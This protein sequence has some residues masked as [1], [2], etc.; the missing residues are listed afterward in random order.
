MAL[1]V[2]DRVQ[3]TCSSPGTGVV[4]LLGAV[5][6]FQTFSA[7]IG[8]AN[9][10]FY[11]I[12]DKTGSNWEVGI[13]TYATT[14]N[15]LT[16]TTIL[17]SSNAGLVVN[18][19]SGTQNVWGDYPA[20]KAI[21]K[22]ASGNAIGLGTPAAFVATN[23]T[24]LPLT[25]GVTGTLPIANGG[26]NSTATPTAGG[27]GYGTG[28]ANAYTA[29]GTS[30]N[31]LISAGASAPAFGN[32][33]LG[34]ANTNVSGALTAT[35]GGTGVAGTLTGVLYGNGTAAHSVATTAQ[36][37]TGMGVANT[38][39]SGY[40]SSTDWNTF[41]GKQAAGSYVTVGGALGTPSSGTLTNCTFPTLNQNTTGSSGSCTGNAATATTATN[42]TTVTA[43][44]LAG[45]V[46]PSTSGNVLTSNGTAWTSATPSGGFAAG[47][48]ILF[49]QAAAP[50]GWTKSATDN[51][52]AL[53]VVSGTTG[54][55]AGGSVAFSTAFAS[56]TPAGTVSVTV[57]IGTLASGAVTLATTQI[58]AHTHT[59]S[60]STN[61]SNGSFGSAGGTGMDNRTTVNSN[62]GGTGGGT[63]HTHTLSGAPSVTSATFTGTAINLAVQYCDVIICTKN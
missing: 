30:G 26:T 5:T 59:Y 11:V 28:T 44:N 27:A 46:T 41:N 24:G 51:D 54:G 43:A 17:A 21:Y 39:T 57:G 34:T 23:V 53:R 60:Y 18:F 12:A 29:A 56:K 50:T 38:T 42:V 16:R 14:G 15:T 9:T 33:A 4:T 3:E 63:S 22:D 8:N 6:Q 25:T 49:Y 48:A 55:T 35:N 52:K 7:A 1:I 32:L 10:T 37:L 61:A 58:P 19:A 13:G 62:T 2:A 20:G 40:L 47:T 45:A 36:M 31:A